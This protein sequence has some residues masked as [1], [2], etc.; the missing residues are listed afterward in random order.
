MM[1]SRLIAVLLLFV[2]VVNAKLTPDYYK[3]TCP[4]FQKIIRET[5]TNKQISTPTTAAGTLRLFMHDC[6]V[7]GCDASVLIASNS[8]NT[9]EKDV[10]INQSLA[11]DAFDVITRAKVA[12]ELACPKTVSCADILA[13]ATRDLVTMVGGPFYKVWLG[14]K[15]GFVS[16]ASRVTG[17]LPTLNMTMDQILDLFQRKGF[18]PQEFVAMMGAHTIGF[19]HC[20]EFTSRIFNYSNTSPHD[21]AMNPSY[22]AGLSKLCE[23]YTTD[24]TMAAFN[25]VMTPG[26]FDN[27]YYKNLPK[28]LGLLSIDQMM[29]TDQRTRP[30]VIQYANNQM[31]FFEAFAHVMEKLGLVDVKTGRK[32]EVRSRCDNFNSL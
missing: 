23:N 25:D 8:F 22:V 30:Y 12:L 10:D 32:G 31:A 19:S 14:R 2:V 16:Q 11:G 24:V 20:K 15:D 17:N 1:G 6:F 28:G 4:D 26:K 9:A 18:A 3:N 27:M 7:E 5:I 13:Q 21:P 29:Y